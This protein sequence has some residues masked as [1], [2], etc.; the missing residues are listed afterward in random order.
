M[1]KAGRKQGLL[2]QDGSVTL[3]PGV[4][5]GKEENLC[6]FFSYKS[7]RV[8]IFFF[9][10]FN[11]F[12]FLSIP[13]SPSVVS[14]QGDVFFLTSYTENFLRLGKCVLLGN[15]WVQVIWWYFFL[16]LQASQDS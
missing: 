14:C 1:I 13:L 5:L 8:L 15:N 9:F 2:A 12:F 10:F 3:W 6:P 4:L 11:V 16:L 7:S